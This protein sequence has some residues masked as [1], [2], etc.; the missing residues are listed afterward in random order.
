MSE[1]PVVEICG[2]DQPGPKVLQQDPGGAER[3]SFR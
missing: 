3:H 1:L 2:V